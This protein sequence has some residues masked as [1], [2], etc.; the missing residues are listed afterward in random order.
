MAMWSFN[1]ARS[2][3]SG[4]FEA[5]EGRVLIYIHKEKELDDV[6]RHYP[7]EHYVLV[8]DKLPILTAVKKNWV[9]RVTTAFPR[10]GR[11]AY[12]AK[13]ACGRD[14]RTHQPIC[15]TMTSPLFWRG[16]NRLKFLRR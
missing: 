8:D 4:I 5:V 10:Q 14:G 9:D 3:R 15:L 11:Y 13:R 2:K 12:D 1:R 7:A 16:N 6:E